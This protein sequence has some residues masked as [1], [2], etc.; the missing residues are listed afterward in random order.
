[1]AAA[2]CTSFSV[3]P[4]TARCTNATLTSSRS[5]FAQALGDGLERAVHVGLED[6][7]E[8]G[9][10]A[11]LD[12]LEDVLELDAGLRWPTACRRMVG[13][14]ARWLAGLGRPCGPSCRRGRRGSRRRRSGTSDRPSTCT[15][16]DGPRLLDVLALVVDEGPHPAPRRAGHDRV[17]DPEGAALDEHGGHRAAADVEVGL[18]HDAAGPALGVGD[19]L[20]D[21]G[22]EQ[23]LLE[24]VVDA[25]ALQ[26]G[27]LRR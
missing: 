3:M 13:G 24:Q 15:G 18:E 2:S 23:E 7:V 20:L 12:L 21:V 14:A 5:S 16:V 1:M 6:H 25:E 22:D 19:E 10:L 17:A 9:R 11:P 4:P 27:D 26:G 8:R